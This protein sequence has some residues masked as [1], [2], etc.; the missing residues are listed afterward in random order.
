MES[1]YKKKKKIHKTVGN[2]FH[3]TYIEEKLN[4][5]VSVDLYNWYNICTYKNVFLYIC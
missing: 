5:I 2:V 3:I 4:N 1:N